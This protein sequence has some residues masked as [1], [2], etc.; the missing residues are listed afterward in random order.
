MAHRLAGAAAVAPF[1]VPVVAHAA[2][3]ALPAPAVF[4]GQTAPDRQITL[5]LS[6]PSRDPQGARDFVSH[7][8]KPGDPLYRHYVSPR[9]YAARF[10]ARQSD[11][12]AVLAWAIA[13]GL[14][15]GERYAARTVV[16]LTG[17]AASIQ[18]AL[19][20]TFQ[21]FRDARGRVFYAARGRTRLPEAI[22][23]KVEGVIGLSSAAHYAPQFVVLPPGTHPNV[24]GTGPNGAYSAADLRSIYTVPSLPFGQQS[25]TLAVFEQG[26]FA[27]SDVATYLKRNTLPNVPAT[28]RSVDGYGGGIDDAGVE[29][30]AVLDIDMV[31][32]MNPAAKQVL[33]YE[34]GT[35]S[36]QVALLDSLS[37]MASDDKAATISISYGEDEA[38][39][40]ADAIA[41][42]N[43]VLTQLA[44]QGQAVFASSG[45]DGAFGNQT[46]L[47]N[48][49]DPASQPLVTGVGGLTVF[50]GPNGLLVQEV[51]NDLLTGAGAG[52]GGISTVWPIPGYQKVQ[53]RSVAKGAGGSAKF[54]NVPDVSSVANPLTGV[55]VYS[56]ANG[57]WLTIGGTSV[58]APLWAGFYSVASAASESFGLGRLGFANPTLYRLPLDLGIVG[59]SLIDV[60][61][62]TNGLFKGHKLLGFTATFGFD[63]A[64]GYGSFF[65]EFTLPDLV[66]AAASSGNNAPPS[67]T[68]VLATVTA[69]TATVSWAGVPSASGYFVALQNQNTAQESA[70]LVKAT[71]ATFTGLVPNTPYLYVVASVSPGGY[72][73]PPPSGFST[74]GTGK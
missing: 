48:V 29:L 57:G 39:Q 61:D 45:D 9:E 52:G 3:Y 22:A 5:A 11:Y 13:H 72:V 21:D 69:R 20:V 46:N 54:R 27:A 36:F 14:T 74:L 60:V 31:V 62:G 53:G 30:E 17:P 35:D 71:S 42:E 4:V 25:Q 50:N 58:S 63:D 65:G 34:D 19:G 8:S 51:W 40:G 41:A 43:A 68:R 2:G 10:G 12:D 28:F 16:P 44:A 1:V 38:L 32:A 55:A 49:S 26:G 56:A 67:P 73:I 23:G 70:A 15:V 66:L 59:P 7:V 37:A 64:S 6:L 47:L 33:V 18:A 24:S